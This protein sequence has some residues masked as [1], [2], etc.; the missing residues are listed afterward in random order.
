MRTTNS[1]AQ[2]IVLDSDERILAAVTAGPTRFPYL[3][4]AENATDP[5]Q[6]AYIF[7]AGEP[8][9]FDS[10]ALLVEK[11]DHRAEVGLCGS[12]CRGRSA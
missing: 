5:H 9:A 7:A 8:V 11:A 6:V 4:E 1:I 3:Q 10:Y 12:T 2:P